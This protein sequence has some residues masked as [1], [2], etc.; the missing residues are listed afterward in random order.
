MKHAAYW[1]AFYASL[2]R[3]LPQDALSAAQQATIDAADDARVAE[4]N[5]GTDP[6]ILAAREVNMIQQSDA[7]QDAAL[8]RV[9]ADIQ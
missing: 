6:D 5:A 3:S 7:Q 8:D 2:L 1:T 4:L 9:L